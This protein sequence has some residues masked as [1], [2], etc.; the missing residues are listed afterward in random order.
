MSVDSSPI[1]AFV[2]IAF[3]CTTSDETSVGMELDG[4]VLGAELGDCS[5]F[6]EL[7]AASSSWVATTN[8]PPSRSVGADVAR[9]V[10]VISCVGGEVIEVATG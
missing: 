2:L 9:E 8:I 7:G 6:L 4:R 1:V 10:E 3:I 5:W